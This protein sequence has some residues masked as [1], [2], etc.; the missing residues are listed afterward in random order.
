MNDGLKQAIS[1]I[2]SAAEL[3]RLL[4]ISPQAVS[5]WGGVIPEL[6]ARQIE[7]ILGISRHK[8]RPDLWR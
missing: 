8:L 7:E 4:G 3:A 2:G 1:K 5:Q 6:R